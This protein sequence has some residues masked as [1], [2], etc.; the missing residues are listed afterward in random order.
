MAT[1]AWSPARPALT[2]GLFRSKDATSVSNAMAFHSREAGTSLAA[3]V[4]PGWL[5]PTVKSLGDLLQ[6]HRDWDGY[7]ADE[8]QEHIAQKALWLLVEVMDNDSPSPSVVP[9]NDGGI[10][11]EWHRHGR[12]L[13]IEF[14]VAAPPVFFYYEDASELETEGAVSRGYNHIQ[15]YLLHLR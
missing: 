1:M 6:L 11:L 8:V 9:L 5:V 12:N 7:G 2:T 15:E 3:P 13:E 14:P 10:Q 4:V